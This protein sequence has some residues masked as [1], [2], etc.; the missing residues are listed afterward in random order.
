MLKINNY[1]NY[2]LKNIS[3]EIKNKNLIILGSNGAGKTT[4]AKALCGIISNNSV[5][6][7][8]KNISK[9]YG[10]AKTKLINYIPSKLDI[11]DEYMSVE[12]FLSLNNLYGNTKIDEALELLQIS[13][14]KNKSCKNLSS[15]ESQLLLYAGAIL[16]NASYTILDE[17]TS[18]LD[19]IKVK[20]M[21]QILQ[22]ENLLKN[23]IIITH[24]LNLA[25]KLE[26]DVLFMQNG[27]IKFNGTNANFFE[28]ENLY[29]FFGTSVKK[30]NDNILVNL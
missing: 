27:E 29:K 5:E 10:N 28:K 15:G 16:H 2:I 21:Y 22:N 25:Y 24:N 4:L 1:N 17:P 20:M 26:Y 9:T 13:Y 3:F 6:I 30:I 12:E 11:F 14:L 7:N 19:P 18:N 8:D 23:K